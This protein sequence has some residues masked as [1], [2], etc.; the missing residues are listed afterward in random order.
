MIDVS[1]DL[2]KTW[3]SKVEERLVRDA[4]LLRAYRAGETGSFGALIEA[5]RAI[6][7]QTVRTTL[8]GG[9]SALTSTEYE[10]LW[11]EVY[12]GVAE[13]ANRFDPSR[14][15]LFWTYA[16]SYV[17]G[18]VFHYLGW[19]HPLVRVSQSAFQVLVRARRNGEEP[20]LS[21]RVLKAIRRRHV[22]VSIHSADSH[23]D[24]DE[25]H[26]PLADEAP[27]A[28]ELLDDE[29]IR[30]ATCKRLV[31]ALHKLLNEREATILELRFVHGYTLEACGQKFGVSRERVRQIE[32]GA[33][34]KG[35]ILLG[36]AEGLDFE[37]W[38]KKAELRLKAKEDGLSRR[39]RH[40]WNLPRDRRGHRRSA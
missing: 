5:H 2:R 16:V 12:A 25:E 17:R 29:S 36:Y 6:L 21:E 9:R 14:G 30:P 28:D 34:E 35:R 3:T 22:Y 18:R 27:P 26:F 20:V 1:P 39:P 10:D 4:E 8:R 33:L 11:Q 31:G 19:E 13:A 7:N 23:T 24:E 32:E 40:L 15:Y 37:T 38:L